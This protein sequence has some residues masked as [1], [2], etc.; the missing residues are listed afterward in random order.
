MNIKSLVYK[1]DSVC[2]ELELMAFNNL[3]LLVG[4]TGVGKTRILNSILHLK[5]IARGASGNG[6]TWAVEFSTIKGLDYKWS[7]IF[8]AKGPVITFP[9]SRNDSGDDDR[10][11]PIIKEEK[12]FIKDALVIDRDNDGIKF[13]G[14][15][16]VKLSQTKSAISLLKE[17]DQIKDV[18]EE[19]ERVIFDDNTSEYTM[20]QPIIFDDKF[21]EKQKKY[22]D[23]DSIRDSGEDIKSKLYW[24][25][26]NQKP[27]FRDIASAFMEIFTHI[28]DVKIAPLSQK[29]NKLPPFLTEEPF[30]QIKERGVK[31]WIDEVKLSA[32]MLRT[33]M[34]I[35]ELHLCADG[36][37]ILIDEFENSL[38]INCIDELTSSIVGTDRHLGLVK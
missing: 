3:T 32:G 36:T 37:V 29:S 14:Q 19:F 26:V 28:D 1:D 18:Y 35:A 6:I 33:L 16:T 22:K 2:W 15:K 23:L 8:E 12:L 10:Y 34:H 27:A 25:Y 7:G 20:G 31:N 21:K 38:G 13:N 5:R 24:T 17:E 30:I 11:L 9:I 4:A